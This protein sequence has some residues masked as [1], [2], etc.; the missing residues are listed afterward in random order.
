MQAGAVALTTTYLLFQQFHGALSSVPISQV[1][2]LGVVTCT[3]TQILLG[4]R[5]AT[6]P[7]A[8]A[9]ERLPVVVLLQPSVGSSEMAVQSLAGLQEP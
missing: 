2:V 1:R 5:K 4:Y 7:G 3:Q 8:V 6:Q 9:Y